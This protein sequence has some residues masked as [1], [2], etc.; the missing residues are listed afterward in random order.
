MPTPYWDAGV[1]L[2]RHGRLHG[3]TS[4]D[5]AIVGGG[6]TGLTAAYLLTRAGR[7]VALLERSALDS[8]DTGATTAHLTCVTDTRLSEL[9][10]AFGRDHA[11]AVWDAGLAAIA[12]IDDIVRTEG[13]ECHFAWVPG[14]LHA[15]VN[16]QAGE[17]DIDDLRREAD[18]AADL[19]FDAQFIDRAPLVNQPAIEFMDQARFHPRLYLKG[20]IAAIERA[21]GRLYED[22][23]V[24]DIEDDPLVVVTPDGRVD[25]RHVI[26]ATH[27]PI[28]G[29]AG[30]LR[31]T[32]L[33]TKL[34]LYSSYAIG[35]QVQRGR[36]PDAL[37]WDTGDPYR[38]L[39]IDRQNGHDMVIYG[40]EDHKTGQADDTAARFDT[41]SAALRALVPGITVTN[42][43]SGQVIE[44]S[45][46]LPYIGEIA[47]RQFLAT[48][49]SGNGMTFGTLGAV[50]AVDAIDERRNPWHEL[51][52]VDRTKIRGGLWDYLRENKDYPYYLI[53]D[54]FAG[55]D[56][57]SVRA[58]RRGSGMVLDLN[59]HRVAAYR[60]D[61][62]AVTMKSAVCT[63]M[64][65]YVHWNSAEGTWDCPCHGSR[66][67]ATGEVLAGPATEPL[68][69]LDVK[70]EGKSQKSK[71]ST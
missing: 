37:F 49:F 29:K 35:G 63:H 25:C 66:F 50:M 28:P 20:L 64:G 54:R 38:Y 44:T 4:C 16:A 69:E 26:I 53:R 67:Q 32:L 23:P 43:W 59:G 12:I 61:D 24:A 5:V 7:K 18:T 58:I 71:V 57:K 68:E 48:G 36:V 56:G 1:P 33:Q 3:H 40:G 10:S 46:G 31:T 17:Q 30:F 55:P 45:D 52:D 19:G 9:V 65:C 13:I 6:I 8:V 34:A 42:Q 15:P 2:R 70:S 51:F 47:P 60:N 22:S 62:G 14:Y 39:R 11:Q 27:N 41:L 21:G